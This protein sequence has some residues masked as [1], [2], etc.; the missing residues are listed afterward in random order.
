MQKLLERFPQEK[1][2]MKLAGSAYFL[3]FLS[4]IMEWLKALILE[5]MYLTLNPSCAKHL[6]CVTLSKF[7]NLFGPQ[8]LHLKS[9]TNSNIYLIRM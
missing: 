1:L 7:S 6:L 3:L 5:Q 2:S 9:E 8:F 4:T